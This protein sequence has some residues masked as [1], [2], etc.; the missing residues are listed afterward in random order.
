MEDQLASLE[1]LGIEAA[2]LNASSSKEEVNMVHSVNYIYAP[3]S[4]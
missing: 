4:Y 3:G 2:K 1:K